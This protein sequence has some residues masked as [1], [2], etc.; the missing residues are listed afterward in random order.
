[1]KT[2]SFIVLFALMAFSTFANAEVY[3]GNCGAETGGTN[4]QWELNTETGL[5]K[6]TGEGEMK[7]YGII[8][9]RPWHTYRSSITQISLPSGLTTV[10]EA[11]FR[12]VPNLTSISIPNT[13]T[14]IKSGAF[15][16]C[17]NLQSIIFSNSLNIIEG[18]AFYNCRSLQSITLPNSLVEIRGDA[19]STCT[20]LISLTIPNGVTTISS[21]AFKNC[22]GLISV[23]IG[24]GVETINEK[25][26]GGCDGLTAVHI[27]NLKQWCEIDFP[28]TEGAV[29]SG[30]PLYY[31]HNLYLNGNLITDLVIPN[32][33]DTI[34][35]SAFCNASFK[36]IT[37]PN[38][39]TTIQKGAFYGC[40]ELTTLS[41]SNTVSSIETYAFYQCTNLPSVSIPSGVKAIEQCTFGVCSSLTDVQ[42]PNGL[43]TIAGQA[44]YNCSSLPSITIPETVISIGNNAFSS[45]ESLKSVIWNAIHCADLS[46]TPFYYCTSISFGNNVEVIPARICYDSNNLTS[47]TIPSSVKEIGQYAFYR[48]NKVTSVKM[49][50]GIE[51]LGKGVFYQCLA[52]DTIVL[53]NSVLDA[54]T[55]TFYGC[56]VLKHLVLSNQLT[57]IGENLCNGC[58]ALETIIIPATVQTIGQKAFYDCKK[59]KFITCE[60]Q[61][62][63]ACGTTV[64]GNVDKS[65]PLYVPAAK[66]NDYK[67]ADQWKDFLDIRPIGDIYRVTFVDWAGTELYAEYVDGGNA[68][69]APADPTRTGYS[70]IGWDKAIDNVTEYMT[71]TAQYKINRFEVQF[72][73][74]NDTIL[75][76]DSVDWHGTA[77][78][79]EN[80]TRE[81]YSFTSWNKKLDDITADLVVKAQFTINYYDVFFLD[82]EGSI[83]KQQSVKYNTAA[84]APNSPTRD[85]YTF[86]GWSGEI[87]HVNERVFAVA[88]YEPNQPTFTNMVTYKDKDGGVLFE[89]GVNLNFPN[90]P[91]YADFTFLG[92]MTIEGNTS[93]GIVVQAIYKDNTAT[94]TTQ[95]GAAPS[96]S[97]HKVLRDGQIYILRGEKEYTLTGQE[98][99]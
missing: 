97:T 12:D 44:F 71:V 42:L 57:A 27:S 48:C 24:T 33:I 90:A 51:R 29:S 99:Q 38:G 58:A 18:S 52:L 36:S 70:F 46:G 11:A 85:G 3:S 68:A 93:E 59:L 50:N 86:K 63:P 28:Y 53:P 47:F 92:W 88:Q 6:I 13:V 62:P 21:Y 79:P 17:Q 5:L 98:V 40:K 4:L 83:L 77:V 64:F 72:L 69:T 78:A 39:V 35:S 54:G 65:T 55:Y 26:F 81:G 20:G 74:W 91:E 41:I 82:Y 25:A 32:G 96:Q 15:Y 23:T 94:S 75:K 31:A 66:I 7:N 61:T 9:S 49:N 8:Q 2:K 56:K 89:E 19:F 76:I 84:T 1:M 37:I 16:D 60:A 34:K 45:C 73:N 67:A 14:T 80:P 22:T 30:N 43:E 87:T 95:I 10:G